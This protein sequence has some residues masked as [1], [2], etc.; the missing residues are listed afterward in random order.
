VRHRHV[1]HTCTNSSQQAPDCLATEIEYYV[2]Y[3][4]YGCQTA[5]DAAPYTIRIE[6][7]PSCDVRHGSCLSIRM[8]TG[9]VTSLSTSVCKVDVIKVSLHDNKEAFREFFLF[10]RNFLELMGSETGYIG[11][12]CYN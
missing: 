8:I 5:R 1:L 2:D 9:N 10:D 6:G 4:G 12:L 7:P 3:V 11:K